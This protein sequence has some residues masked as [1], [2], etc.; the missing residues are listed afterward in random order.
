ME[1]GRGTLDISKVG[2]FLIFKLGE[3]IDLVIL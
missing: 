2:H 1:S 3:Y